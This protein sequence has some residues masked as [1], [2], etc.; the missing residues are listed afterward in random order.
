MLIPRLRIL[1]TVVAGVITGSRQG[2][3]SHVNVRSV[4]RGTPNA[5]I[6]NPLDIFKPYDG[7]LIKLSLSQDTYKIQSPVNTADA[8][9]WWNEHR[10]KLPALSKPDDEYYTLRS[11]KEM[12][13]ED[14]QGSLLPALWR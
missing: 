10:P 7:Q 12:G 5:Y 2:E 8:E 3:L 4:R 13:T 6:K 11:L 14:F 1:K 9:A